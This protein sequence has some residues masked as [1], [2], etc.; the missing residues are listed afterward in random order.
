MSFVSSCRYDRFE[1]AL[2]GGL[3]SSPFDEAREWLRERNFALT[4]MV[5]PPSDKDGRGFQTVRQYS[6]DIAVHAEGMIVPKGAAVGIQSGDC[7][8]V[9]AYNP[10]PDTLAITHAG[11]PAL[12]PY[13]NICGYNVVSALLNAVAPGGANCAEVRIYITA[14]IC[15][16]CF[17][18]EKPDAQKLIAPFRDKFPSAIVGGHGLDL[19]EVIRQGCIRRG[20]PAENIHHDG[21]CTKEHPS[22]A[23]YCNGDNER[24]LTVVVHY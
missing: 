19:V 16:K 1:T 7:S 12:T 15:G 24:N 9:T 14:A 8:I 6:D 17:Q 23:S 20:V 13:D 11:R 18:H 3:S 5:F 4:Y 22:L 2:F 10:V 21:L